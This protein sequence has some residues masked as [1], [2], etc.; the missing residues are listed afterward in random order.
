VDNGAGVIESADEA[1]QFGFCTGAILD[2]LFG[3]LDPFGSFVFGEEDFE[4]VGVYQPT[5]DYL[6]D[7][8]FSFG[9][10]LGEVDDGVSN[11]GVV[12]ILHAEY[13][14]EDERDGVPYTFIVVSGVDTGLEEVVDETV[15]DDV[16]RWEFDQ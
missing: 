6:S 1:F 8:K 14:F 3:V 16:S 4:L 10:V 13:G 7:L 5:Q 15:G 2:A 9:L 12:G 11:G